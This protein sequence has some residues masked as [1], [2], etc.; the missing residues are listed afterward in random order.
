MMRMLHRA[1]QM[2]P[3][4]VRTVWRVQQHGGAGCGQPQHVVARDELELMAADEAGLLDQVGRMDRLWSEAQM[5]DRLR[6]RLVRVVDEIALRVQ[7]GILGDDLHAVL[8]GAHRAVGA[9]TV[10]H[11]LHQ[12]LRLD[13]EIR[14]RR[15]AGMR[16]IVDD[17]DGEAVARLGPAQFVEHRLGHRRIEILRRQPVAAADHQRHRRRWPRDAACASVLTTSR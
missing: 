12:I 5:R 1:R 10:E 16:H 6:A 2:V 8:V 7:S 11:R 9:E 3:D 13:A 4:L 14:I 17:A 15:Q